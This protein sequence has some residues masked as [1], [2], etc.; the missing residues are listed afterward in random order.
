MPRRA[1]L[2]KTDSEIICLIKQGGHDNMYEVLYSRYYTK[3]TDK[4]FSFLKDKPMAQECAADILSKAYEKLPGFTG[5]SSFSS[6]LYAIT[7]NFCIDYLRRVKK[8]HYPSWNAD[9]ELPEI[10][11][12]VE[13]D[14]SDA[15][16]ELLMR[17]LDEIHPE[18]KAL[19]E[20][21]YQNDL[22]I[23]E[24]SEALEISESAVKMR[25][26]RAKARIM[27]LYKEKQDEE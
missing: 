1:K 23:K 8:L 9:H 18:E 27:F 14:W 25:L 7:Y 15:N 13:D 16:G 26:K 4:C 10:I 21:K 12:E 22:S 3:V 17:I 19:I 24:I 5:Q 2:Q 20:M 6:W 11:D